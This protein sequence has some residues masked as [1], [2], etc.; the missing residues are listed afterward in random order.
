MPDEIM[1]F[2]LPVERS[3]IIK[4]LG[5]GGGGNN[6]V[7]HMFE[8]GIRDVNFIVCNTDHQSLARSPVP[9]KVQ[10][11]ESLTEG[12]GAG[13][14]P[15]K[16]KK[17]AME[18][19]N[20]VMNALGGN[21][22]M[23]FLTTGMGGGT[24]TGAIPVI[25]KACRDAGLLTI[26]V[27][28]IPF[29]S[30]GKIRIRY[31]IDGITEL[32]DYV[33]SLLVINNEKLREIYG[34]QGVS[35]AFA[36]ADDILTTAVKGIAEII[37]VT[38][39]INVDFADVETVMKDSGVAVMG[40][41]MAAGENR[42]IS[43]IE[44]A[45]ASPLLN[46]N[47]ITG[48][49]SILINI[50]S[51]T[52]KYELTM[53]ELGEI[54]D[55][56]YEVASDDA[57]IIRGLSQDE[58]LAENISV[59]VIAT[60]FE[61]NSIFQPYKAKKQKKVEILESPGIVPPKIIPQRTEENFTVH[62]RGKH[63]PIIADFEEESQGELDFNLDERK[64][65]RGRDPDDEDDSREKPEA[66]LNKVKHIQ[67]MLKKEGLS[68]KTM[69]ENIDTFEDVPAYIRRNMSLTS[70]DASSEESKLSKFTLTSDEDEGPVLRENNAYLND[71]VD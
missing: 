28:T 30:E 36:K 69:K 18:N 37:T 11:G 39:Y 58:S 9:L 60:G 10:I 53:D 48:A 1:N 44:N 42:A 33:D 22:R 71:N 55:Y 46:S 41:G 20:N 57:L 19:I 23:V 59:T 24:G 51:G 67:N 40:M 12:M 14:Q 17:A 2:D 54:T 47:D 50:S 38:G 7:N 29:K 65:A 15:E 4:V 16:G 32:K 45:L 27:V 52:G 21:T 8:K 34:N 25:A 56:I 3:S 64:A 6:A 5:I 68:N 43:A 70:P 26:A 13:S 31:A 61:A 62:E 49:K 35:S 63:K 66:T